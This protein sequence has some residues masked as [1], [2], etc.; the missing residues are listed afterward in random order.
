MDAPARRTARGKKELAMQLNTDNLNK[1][2]SE[3]LQRWLNQ[4]E[5]GILQRVLEAEAFQH[6]V[7]AANHLML[8]TDGGEKTAATDKEKALKTRFAADLIKRLKTDKTF[9]IYSVTPT[10]SKL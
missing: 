3:R 2:E 4:M 6:E 10:P 9:K 5:C 1:T 8:D 7:N